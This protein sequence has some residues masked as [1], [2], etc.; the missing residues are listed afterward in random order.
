MDPPAHPDVA[1]VV[2]GRSRVLIHHG[3]RTRF[4]STPTH[5]GKGVR[6]H[7]VEHAIRRGD[8]CSPVGG[9]KGANDYF[10]NQFQRGFLSYV[11]VLLICTHS[12]FQQNVLPK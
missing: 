1:L 10:G 3:N 8:D 6:P 11:R 7:T 2:V 9:P 5:D 4:D 12:R